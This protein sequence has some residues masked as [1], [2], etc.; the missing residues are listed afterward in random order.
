M[1]RLTREEVESVVRTLEWVLNATQGDD[2]QRKITETV[3]D[4]L[5][6]SLKVNRQDVNFGVDNEIDPG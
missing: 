5:V 3:I 2:K 4:K 1:L 6:C